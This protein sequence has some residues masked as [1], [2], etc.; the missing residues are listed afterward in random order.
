MF[1][2]LA[3]Y[4]VVF[5]SLGFFACLCYFAYLSRTSPPH[6]NPVTGQ[7]AQ[8]ND[9]GYFFYVYP[10]QGW[11]LDTGPIACVGAI[12]AMAGIVRRSSG[13]LTTLTGP[14]W[15]WWV[16]LAALGTCLFYV[17]YRFP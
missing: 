7:V 16:Y 2:R 5:A 14:R 15:L 10:W 1:R 8:M 17:F 12:F 4:L 9:H 6:A 3:P 11:V 13:N